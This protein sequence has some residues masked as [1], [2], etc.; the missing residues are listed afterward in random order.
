MK[1][2][3]KEFFVDG[4]KRYVVDGVIRLEDGTISGSA[5]TMAEGVKNLLLS[6]VSICDVSK[7]A[8]KNPAETLGVYDITGS[9]KEGK[10]ADFAVLDGEYNV[11][12][13][14]VDG[15]EYKK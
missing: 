1:A 11:V 8:S 4:I 15:E 9:I 13:A 3:G 5:M 14:F 7:M 6:G 10:C 2:F 12:T